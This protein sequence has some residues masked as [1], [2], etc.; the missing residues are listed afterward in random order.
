MGKRG[1]RKTPTAVLKLHGSRAVEKRNGEP[2]PPAGRPTCPAF[3]SKYGKTTWKSLVPMLD[4]MGVLSKID[5]RTLARYCEE[6]SRWRDAAKFLQ[7]NGSA[8]SYTDND[9]VT[10]WKPY[11]QA[12][13][14]IQLAE[15]ML[16]IESHFGLTPSARASLKVRPTETVQ[17]VAS[18]FFGGP[19]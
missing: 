3:L 4:E 16:R 12:R 17:D 10:H 2:T 9:G 18:R 13:E 11:P 15:S 7:Q 5:G 8:Y 6:W 1:P 14:F 19:A